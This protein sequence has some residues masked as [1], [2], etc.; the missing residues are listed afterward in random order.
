MSDTSIKITH[1]VPVEVQRVLDAMTEENWLQGSLRS[2]FFPERMCFAGHAE[3]IYGGTQD[4]LA[5][6]SWAF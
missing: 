2:R 1:A 6:C 5:K 4:G 3:A